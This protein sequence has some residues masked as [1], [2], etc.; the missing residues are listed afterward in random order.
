MAPKIFKGL[1]AIF[2]PVEHTAITK[3]F[4]T[5]DGTRERLFSDETTHIIAQSWQDVLD[6][7]A[8]FMGLLP[9]FVQECEIVDEEWVHYCIAA[10]KLMHV[11]PFYLS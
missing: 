9:F 8:P 1:K 6:H 2:L 5:R 4:Q 11:E 3:Q 7:V 10:E